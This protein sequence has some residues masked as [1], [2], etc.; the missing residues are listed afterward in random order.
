MRKDNHGILLIWF[1]LFCIVIIIIIVL[2]QIYTWSLYPSI[3]ESCLI[4]KK[5]YKK[6]NFLINKKI[7]KFF[8][9]ILIQIIGW[10]YNF[11]KWWKIDYLN[12]LDKEIFLRNI[13]SLVSIK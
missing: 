3:F 12:F 5:N 6:Y 10:N 2:I 9:W 8:D 4:Y 7:I 11:H 1:A 13:I